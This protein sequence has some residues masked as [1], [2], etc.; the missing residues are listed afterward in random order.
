MLRCGDVAHVKTT[1]FHD[2]DD[3]V[4]TV[5]YEEIWDKVLEKHFLCHHDFDYVLHTASP[6]THRWA[7]AAKVTLDPAVKVTIET[8]RSIK[9]HAPI[10]KPVVITSSFVTLMESSAYAQVYDESVWNSVIWDA[11]VNA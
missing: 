8:L 6:S 7:D 1:N 10:M 3:G 5:R 2:S 11:A 9:T 4:V